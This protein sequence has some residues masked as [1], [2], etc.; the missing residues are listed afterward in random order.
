[1]GSASENLQALI[2]EFYS[3]WFRFH[4]AAVLKAGV[5]GYA[6]TMP[7]VRDDDVGA[8]GSWLESTIVG[9]EEIDF[10]A[11]DPAEQLDLELLFGAC[12]DEYQAILKRDWRH[13]DPLAFMPFQTICRLLLDTGGE[14]Q[15]ALEACL[16]GIPSFL[17]QARSVLAEFPAFIPRIWINVALRE[18]EAG[19]GFL[20]QLSDKGDTSAGLRALCDQVAQAVTEYLK[21]LREDIA[22]AAEGTAVCGMQ[23]F[24]EQLRLRH[25]LPDSLDEPLEM[26]RQIYQETRTEL[27]VLSLEQTG[28]SDPR[29][30]LEKLSQRDPLQGDAKLR[31]V[32]RRQLEIHSQLSESGQFVMPDSVGLELRQAPDE[33]QLDCAPVYRSPVTG[34]G[35][36]PGILYLE[37]ALSA[38]RADTPERLTAWCIRNAWPGRHLQAAAAAASPYAGTLVRRVNHS[39]SQQVGWSLYAEQLMHDLGYF[40]EPEHTLHCLLERLRRSLLAVLDIELHVH[41]MAASGALLQLQALPGSSAEEAAR[42]LLSLTRHPTQHLAGVLAWKL[43]DALRQWQLSSGDV[44]PADFHSL[45]LAQGSIALPL[46]IRRVFGEQAWSWVEAQVYSQ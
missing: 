5:S 35:G 36:S 23:R 44:A 24:Q 37:Q 17:R 32:G 12:R 15:A 30:W 2:R 3:V 45:L 34:V 26:V 28:S 21:F 11:L 19:V 1:M 31:Y 29:A 7:A 40:P 33:C 20:R 25:H 46:V 38:G 4:P 43:L 42:D 27:A 8:L 22:P 6:G 10:H 14:G 9:L 13:R 18:G 41:G 39:P 16:E